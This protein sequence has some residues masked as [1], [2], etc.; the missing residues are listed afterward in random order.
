MRDVIQLPSLESVSQ[1]QEWVLDKIKSP[2]VKNIAL[3]SYKL[4]FEK[5]QGELNFDYDFETETVSVIG[6]GFSY[7][8]A[9]EDTEHGGIE[10]NLQ[11][12]NF[13]KV[14]TKKWLEEKTLVRDRKDGEYRP[15]WEAYVFVN[16][17]IQNYI[18]YHGIESLFDVEEKEAKQ[19]HEHKKNGKK[20]PVVR[21]YK[22]YTL[23]KDWESAPRLKKPIKYTC[24]AWGV[25]GHIRHLKD[26]REIYVRPCVKGKD[27]SKY[28]GK[29]YKLLKEGSEAV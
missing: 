21:L 8:C 27:R 20:K 26:G 23:K 22:C 29:E 10:F 2:S 18:C 1:M 28:V 5:R 12:M 17:I 15:R 13:D 4:L 7:V 16:L 11:K 25:R 9:P 6:V 24:P 3:Q 14:S 19:R